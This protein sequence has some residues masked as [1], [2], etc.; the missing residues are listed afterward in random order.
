MK[1]IQVTDNP[2]AFH[3]FLKHSFLHNPPL[4]YQY[5]PDQMKYKIEKSMLL[6]VPPNLLRLEPQGRWEKMN[7]HSDLDIAIFRKLTLSSSVCCL[8]VM[9]YHKPFISDT[10]YLHIYR[11]K[12]ILGPFH[13]YCTIRLNRTH[14]EKKGLVSSYGFRWQPWETLAWQKCC[15]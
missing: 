7:Y 15:C 1:N 11:Y 4:K 2:I 6:H 13:R 14:S 5:H 8:N 9:S 3:L 12:L 10:L